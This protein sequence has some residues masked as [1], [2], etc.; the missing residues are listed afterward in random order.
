MKLYL[1]FIVALIFVLSNL[2]N[3]FVTNLHLNTGHQIGANL[4]NLYF[5]KYYLII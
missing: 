1:V 3:I 5:K 2:L 4:G